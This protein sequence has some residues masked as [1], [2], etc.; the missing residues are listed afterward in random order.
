MLPKMKRPFR[1]RNGGQ[2]AKEFFEADEAAVVT[3]DIEELGIAQ[4]S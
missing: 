4:P 2:L 1:A 3:E